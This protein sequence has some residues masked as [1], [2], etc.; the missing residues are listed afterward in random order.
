MYFVRG[1]CLFLVVIYA[2]DRFNTPATNRSSTRRMLYWSSCG[3]YIICA[4][5]L[6]V[7]RGEGLDL[8]RYRFTRVLQLYRILRTLRLNT[9]Y[10]KFFSDNEAEFTDLTEAFVRFARRS[11]TVLTL[12]ANVKATASDEVYEELMRDK[13]EEYRE[14][15]ANVFRLL[16]QFLAHAVLRSE[17][18]EREIKRTLRG[19]GFEFE[20]PT[21]PDFPIH[22]LT[23][24]GIALLLMLL[25]IG[26]PLKPFLP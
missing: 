12:A 25:M 11:D 26:G 24:L 13:R 7:V 8:S 3:G 19:G 23:G 5:A 17:P 10:E 2:W 9:R 22:S 21:L 15:C 6:R 14:N 1:L 20:L 18:G 4:V 16:A